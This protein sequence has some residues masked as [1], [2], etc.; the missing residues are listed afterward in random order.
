M[1]KRDFLE[2][3]DLSATELRTVLDL[4][5]RPAAGLGR[6]LE[7]QGVAL[8]FEKPSNRTRQ[9]MEMAVV[10]LGGHPVYTR[11]EEIQFDYSTTMSERRWTSQ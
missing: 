3:T 6:P 11:G 4:A 8:V 1:T 7:G 2:V 10:Q 9:S 5:A